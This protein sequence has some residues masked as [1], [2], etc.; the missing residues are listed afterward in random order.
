MSYDDGPQRAL[1]DMDGTVPMDDHPESAVSAPP[2]RRP[3]CLVRVA[4]LVFLLALLSGCAP[5]GLSFMTPAG[6]VA[7]AERAHLITVTV[8][9][10]VVVLPV[11]LGV[12]WIALRYR[13]RR[14]AKY[15]PDWA[16]SRRLEW[17]MW[18]VPAVVVVVLGW[19]LAVATLRLDPYRHLDPGVPP[20][21]V[22]AIALDWKW[23]FLY[24]ELGVASLNQLALPVDRPVVI[25]LT[26]DTVMQSFFV[27]ALG[28][29]IY[30]MP[31]MQTKMNLLVERPGRFIGR[32]T[33]Y[34]GLG[35][36]HQT[37]DTLAMRPAEFAVWTTRVRKTGKRLDAG[38]YAELARASTPA[39]AAAGFAVPG[40]PTGVAWFAPIERGLFD[41]VMHR[42]M[43]GK[44]VPAS[45]Q[46]GSPAYRVDRAE[47]PLCTLRLSAPARNWSRQSGSLG[48]SLPM[49]GEAEFDTPATGAH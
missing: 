21:H 22:E 46:A 7:A 1:L 49:T 35:F 8:I 24:P 12:P 30:A 19:Q 25:R 2:T 31:G 9:A 14:R 34:N 4:G 23:L 15:A 3:Q 18:G 27:G 28:G 37:F 38:S 41:T 40:M 47:S 16:Y 43:S 5:D 48:N 36:Q 13:R 11:L 20:L 6:P 29:Q 26:S 17:V 44:A 10:L 39:Q 45:A 33:Q 42:Y 32:N